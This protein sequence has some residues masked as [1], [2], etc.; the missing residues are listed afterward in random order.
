M[1][2]TQEDIVAKASNTSSSKTSDAPKDTTS[3]SGKAA[4]ADTSSAAKD[5]QS[6]DTTSSDQG[7]IQ[8]AQDAAS[9]QV[10]ADIEAEREA[11]E[12]NPDHPEEAI[13][14]KYIVGGEVPVGAPG[15]EGMPRE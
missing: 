14:Q 11:V 13:E 12:E 5:A 15:T 4:D 8:N 6:N 10:K 2:D 3:T 7:D 1:T 9:D